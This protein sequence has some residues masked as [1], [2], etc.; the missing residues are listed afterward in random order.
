MPA[1]PLTRLAAL[2]AQLA[3]ALASGTGLAA[4][5]DHARLQLAALRAAAEAAVPASGAAPSAPGA[6]SAASP[7]APGAPPEGAAC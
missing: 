3:A 1:D 2:E 5:L 4:R 6:A 7:P